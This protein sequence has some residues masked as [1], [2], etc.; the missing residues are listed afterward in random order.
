MARSKSVVSAALEKVGPRSAWFPPRNWPTAYDIA[1][2]RDAMVMTPPGGAEFGKTE[3]FY[4]GVRDSDPERAA[5]LVAALS[6]ALEKRTKVIREKRAGSMIK[7][8]SKGVDGAEATL[9]SKISLLSNFETEVGAEL[10][11]MRSLINPIGGNSAT[12]QDILAIQTEIRQNETERQR[13]VKL[14]E[15]LNEAQD[16]P[17]MLV[18]TPS[19]LLTSQPPLA[20]L[21]QGLVDAQ[22]RTARLLGRYSA[23]HPHVA[24]ARE[25]EAQVR[26]ELHNELAVATKGIQIELAL[27]QGRNKT[28]QSRLAVKQESQR[29]LA[30]HRAA[31]SRL[32][33]GVEN[34][35]QL[36]EAARTRLADAQVH[37]AG[38]QSSSLLSRIDE[39]ESGLRP[40]GPSRSTVVAVGGLLGLLFGLGGV[41]YLH[42]PATKTQAELDAAEDV[43]TATHQDREP[44]GFPTNPLPTNVSSANA[45]ANYDANVPYAAYRP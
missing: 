23:A 15:V 14:L 25:A 26:Q 1:D 32:V 10:S 21:K 36:V 28:L 38:A 12:S 27:S 7:E 2:F 43:N 22:L 31:Y 16:D 34:Q 45:K 5:A 18:A 6:E 39:V 19:T 35:T 9:D 20:R 8:L 24:S 42:G 17:Q 30:T 37:H 40:V 41:F 44:F 33:A 4:L 11:D 13:N 3:V 29:N